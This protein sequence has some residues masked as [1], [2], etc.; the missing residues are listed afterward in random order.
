MINNFFE[1]LKSIK[2]KT[3]EE[4]RVRA[5]L[6]RMVETP[7]VSPYV[8]APVHSK[9]VFFSSFSMR[10]AGTALVIFMMAGSGLALAAE[11][12]LPGD[13]LYPI[14]IHFSESVK[15]ALVF[16]NEA[17][18]NW[19]EMRVE[20]RLNEIKKLRTEKKLTVESAAIAEA[21]FVSQSKEL[22]DSINALQE[23]GNHEAAR[24]VVEKILPE[25]KNFEGVETEVA[26]NTEVET[27]ISPEV[28]TLSVDSDV[29]IEDATD[30]SNAKILEN[31]SDVAKTATETLTLDD[32][33]AETIANLQKQIESKLVSSINEQVKV[34]DSIDLQKENSD[35]VNLNDQKN[36]TSSTTDKPVSEE[37]ASDSQVL[38]DTIVSGTV[39]GKVDV[40]QVCPTEMLGIKCTLPA[41]IYS[42]RHIQIY[43]TDESKKL[44]SDIKLK[45]DGTYSVSIPE[46]SYIIEVK[47]N[48]TD[49][50]FPNPKT[51]TV[52]SGEKIEVNFGVE[53]K[54]ETKLQV[55]SL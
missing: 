17:E 14:K 3:E 38:S 23:D 20:K 53:Q 35:K 27:E 51:F 26:I 41:E 7:V 30:I 39:Y 36:D 5:F 46:G 48:G 9:Y 10:L 42:S 45:D 2:M 54:A 1:Q 15:S 22:A 18:A 12:S 16:G 37:T 28:S 50:A 33:T 4:S 43:T 40:G 21:T 34:F 13:K 29:K 8:K 24:E 47:K 32:N 11:G 6:E 25:L 55:Q 44:V 49:S 31:V 52:K 19:N